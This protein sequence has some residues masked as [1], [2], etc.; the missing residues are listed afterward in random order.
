MLLRVAE[1]LYWL[2]RYLERAENTANAVDAACHKALRPDADPVESWEGLLMTAGRKTEFISRYGVS[3]ATNIL[4]FMLLD[5]DNPASALSSLRLARENGRSAY[6]T[7]P[8][9]VS[10]SVNSLWLELREMELQQLTLDG[11]APCLDRLREGTLQIHGGFH[12]TL[13]VDEVSRL[14]GLGTFLERGDHIIRTLRSNEI[15]RRAAETGASADYLACS[16]VL[17]SVDALEVYQKTYHSKLSPARVIDLLLLKNETHCSLRTC[18]ERVGDCLT[19]FAEGFGREP[20]RLAEEMSHVLDESRF[21]DDLAGAPEIYLADFSR[22][23]GE[24]VTEIEKGFR[25]PLCA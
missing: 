15:F 22:R 1:H 5:L 2:G 20:K 8:P 17:R 3:S 12:H 13:V 25:I 4:E 14:I 6:A 23:L 21:G 16:S 24:I 7:L 10:E 11:V 19:P 18:I 9:E